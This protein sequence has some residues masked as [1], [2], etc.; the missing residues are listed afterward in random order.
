MAFT[1]LPSDLIAAGKALVQE[2]FSI[3]KGDVDD[4]EDRITV[5]EGGAGV[6]SPI[7]FD[8]TGTLSPFAQ[9]GILVY[10][11]NRTLRITAAR[12]FINVA[13][14]SGTTSIDVEYK[15][16]GGGWTSILTGNITAAFGAGDLY[17]ASGTL[18]D[19]SFEFQ[20]G[21]LIRLNVDSVQDAM[22]DLS[23]YLENEAA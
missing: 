17:T 23:V 19:A 6:F 5:L 14:T 4:H 20:A 15:R 3:L 18:V 8:V 9:D 16:G 22:R 1:T 11:V 10:R 21:D 7:T 2:I 12:L 13:G